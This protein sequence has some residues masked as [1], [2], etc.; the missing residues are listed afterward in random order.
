MSRAGAI[1]PVRRLTIGTLALSGSAT[2]NL[3]GVSAAY[4]NYLCGLRKH[5]DGGGLVRRTD[6]LRDPV[7][8]GPRPLDH[9]MTF[10]VERHHVIAV[11]QHNHVFRPSQLAAQIRGVVQIGVIVLARVNDQRRLLNP[12]QHLLCCRDHPAMFKDHC[13]WSADGAEIRTIGSSQCGTHEFANTRAFDAERFRIREFHQVR[14]PA[15][16]DQRK[17]LRVPGHRPAIDPQRRRKERD[18]LN[19]VGMLG[20]EVQADDAA[21]AETADDDRIAVLADFI[22][23]R[24][25]TPVPV[26]PIGLDDIL[27]RAAMPGQLRAVNRISG[28]TEAHSDETH[29]GGGS[30]QT[31][32]QQ[33]TDFPAGDPVGVVFDGSLAAGAGVQRGDLCGHGVLLLCFSAA[34]VRRRRKE[35]LFRAQHDAAIGYGE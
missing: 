24:F 28:A 11:F 27:A 4:P 12:V 31:V 19:F 3:V 25:G 8:K 32:D 34:T 10:L 15:T 35:A 2:T 18:T 7:D 26:L 30:A 1:E 13:A 14:H 21:E 29:L 6:A 20:G 23:R 33:Y 16:A 5:A 22:E 17:K 9:H